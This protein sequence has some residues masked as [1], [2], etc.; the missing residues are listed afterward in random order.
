MVICNMQKKLLRIAERAVA[1]IA[2]FSLFLNHAPAARSVRYMEVEEGR[3]AV[4]EMN[5]PVER[6]RIARVR[7]PTFTPNSSTTPR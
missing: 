6:V 4:E 3:K 7:R 1:N 2:G 5:I